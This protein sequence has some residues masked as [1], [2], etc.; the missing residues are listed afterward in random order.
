MK[1]AKLAAGY[2]K[3][4]AE[5][6]KA[7][8]EKRTAID[9]ER[10]KF[11]DE[12][13]KSAGF[14]QSGCDDACKAVIEEEILK[15]GKEKLKNCTADEKAI[16]CRKADDLFKDKFA[17]MVGDGEGAKNFFK[18]MDKDAREKF[19]SGFAEKAEKAA[20]SLAAAWLKDNAVAAGLVGGP[21]REAGA[22]GGLCD[23]GSCCGTSVPQGVNGAVDKVADAAKDGLDKAGEALG[24][25]LGAAGDILD[26][27]TGAVKKEVAGQLNKV[28]AKSADQ[29]VGVWTNELGEK[30]DHTCLAQR[31]MATAAA[32]LAAAY[33]LM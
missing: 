7:W 1:D 12:L 24:V 27:V 14:E 29:K 28:C 10:K 2:E 26:A 23:V 30:F 11:F 32:S 20:S 5:D 33:S 4:S 9:A 15:F 21:C 25:D 31:L 6:Q 16:T 22:E 18:D 8:D 13:K 19:E 17:A 3:M